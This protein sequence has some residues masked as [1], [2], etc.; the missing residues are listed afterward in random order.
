MHALNRIL[1]R[2]AIEYRHNDYVVGRMTMGG[3]FE[4]SPACNDDAIFWHSLSGMA[5]AARRRFD[6]HAP[7]QRLRLVRS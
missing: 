1:A 4:I 5:A 6:A 2:P 3:A 7:G